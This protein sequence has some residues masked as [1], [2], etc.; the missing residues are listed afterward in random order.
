MTEDK[1]DKQ[2]KRFKK[3][4]TT[5][6]KELRDSLNKKNKPIEELQFQLSIM[7]SIIHNILASFVENPA[8]NQLAIFDIWSTNTRE[9]I[10]S[11]NLQL[12]PE[13]H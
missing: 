3:L 9:M 10:E 11:I 7:G 8:E 5:L 2:A 4:A 12:A 13:I 1:L 6:Q